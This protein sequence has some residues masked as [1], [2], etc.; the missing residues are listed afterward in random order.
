MVTNVTARGTTITT[1]ALR[2][3]LNDKLIL[4]AVQEAFTEANRALEPLF[5]LE[6]TRAKWS[7][8]TPPLMRD[9]VDTGRLRQSYVPTPG[10]GEYLHSW[11]A[12]YALGVHEGARLANGRTIPA[13]RW[14]EEPL[15]E[16][17]AAFRR[18]A[19]SRLE[20]VR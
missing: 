6:F 7:W 13:R 20:R 3:D 17:P 15:K 19:R 11:N 1:D 5:D 16:L 8:P 4:A 14:T 12:D 2:V 9:I 10:R 18:F